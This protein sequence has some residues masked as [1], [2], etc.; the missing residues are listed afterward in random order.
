MKAE[1]AFVKSRLTKEGATDSILIM[2]KKRVYKKLEP[3]PK[4]PLSRRV[5]AWWGR[6]P[7]W[8]RGWLF[9]L[10][11]C[12]VIWMPAWLYEWFALCLGALLFGAGIYQLISAIVRG[13][14]N[15]WR[16]P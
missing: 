12:P 16:R 7:D 11:L 6:L 10:L 4:E 8:V 1:G 14:L 9:V 5:G 15:R 3:P 2:K 13:L